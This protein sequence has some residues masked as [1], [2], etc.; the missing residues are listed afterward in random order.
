MLQFSIITSEGEKEKFIFIFRPNAQFQ[1]L[2][3]ITS[4][5]EK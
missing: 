1:A 3:I 4:E 2:L 5:G